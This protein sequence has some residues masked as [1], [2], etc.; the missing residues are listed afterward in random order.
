MVMTEFVL[1]EVRTEIP[2]MKELN[3]L[4]QA[5]SSLKISQTLGNSRQNPR[6]KEIQQSFPLSLCISTG[7][8]RDTK[9]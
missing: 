3:S 6:C 9:K 1:C 8:Y 4:T 2:Y 5:K 7:S